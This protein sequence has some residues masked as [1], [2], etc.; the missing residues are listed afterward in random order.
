M[1]TRILHF[2]KIVADGTDNELTRFIDED[3]DEKTIR[4]Y[5]GE[6]LN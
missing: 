4:T 3:K 1:K 5:A 6:I 2:L